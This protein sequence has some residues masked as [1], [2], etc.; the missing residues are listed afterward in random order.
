MRGEQCLRGL[1]AIAIRERGLG[2]APAR[3]RGLEGRRPGL[4]GAGHGVP[5]RWVAAAVGAGVLGLDY[6]I[7]DG[8]ATVFSY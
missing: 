8:E 6:W 3:V 1:G 4:P 7:G 5:A 2:L